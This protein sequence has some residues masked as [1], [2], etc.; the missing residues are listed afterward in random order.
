M[1][2]LE[3]VQ[4][5]NDLVFEI[6]RFPG[7]PADPASVDALTNRA[8]ELLSRLQQVIKD[9]WFHREPLSEREIYARFAQQ[10]QQ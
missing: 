2:P 3:L 1:A 8:L 9:L 6:D 5:L 7:A 10:Q 4:V